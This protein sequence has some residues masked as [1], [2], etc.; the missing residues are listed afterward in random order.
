MFWIE[1]HH[2]RAG[3]TGRPCRRLARAPEARG[4]R[5]HPSTRSHLPGIHIS[6]RAAGPANGAPVSHGIL[7]VC[8]SSICMCILADAPACLVADNGDL[9]CDIQ[10]ACLHDPCACSRTRSI[11]KHGGCRS[12]GSLQKHQRCANLSSSRS[13]PKVCHLI[14]LQISKSAAAGGR[15]SI[16]R[17]YHGKPTSSGL[18]RA[19][20]MV[21]AA[22]GA[23][24]PHPRPDAAGAGV[25]GILL[26]GGSRRATAR[27]AAIL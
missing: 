19:I 21:A 3:E 15:S 2:E 12:G 11:T 20:T 25:A 8:R 14:Q 27:G 26:L 13:A 4:G 10:S 7:H 5:R 23:D 17:S 1:P 22:G 16:K 9:K 24:V 18:G 6:I